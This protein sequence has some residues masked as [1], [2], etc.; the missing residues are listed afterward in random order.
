MYAGFLFVLFVG[1]LANTLISTN[2]QSSA[3]SASS[4]QSDGYLN[5]TTPNP[6][7]LTAAEI[8]IILSSGF[9]TQGN[10]LV[11]FGTVWLLA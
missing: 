3:E 2:A 11:D 10:K 8:S 9:F 1:V 6:S 5:V 4:S 7:R